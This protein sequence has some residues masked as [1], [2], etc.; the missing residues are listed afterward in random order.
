[1][2]VLAFAI[3]GLAQTPCSRYTA[4]GYSM[5]TPAG[6]TGE[7]EAGSKDQTFYAASAGG[8]RANLIFS[9]VVSPMKFAEFVTAT[10]DY[11]LKNYV[12]LGFSSIELASRSEFLTD[13]YEH[14]AK[15]VFLEG[16][17][18]YK[19]CGYQYMFDTGKKK[20]FVTFTALASDRTANE[21]LFDETVKTLKI[22]H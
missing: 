14:G 9:D 20:I 6:W 17:Q 22:D 11:T 7:T 5:C 21:K 19:L 12:S 18:A 8:V 2:L 16:I 1:M 13:T 10:N 15:S 4:D 3:A